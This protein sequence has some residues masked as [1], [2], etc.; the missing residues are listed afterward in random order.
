MLNVRSPTGK[1][2]GRSSHF[3]LYPFPTC[4]HVFPMPRWPHVCESTFYLFVRNGMPPHASAGRNS[5]RSFSLHLSCYY[6]DSGRK[7]TH[8]TSSVCVTA[9]KEGHLESASK[10]LALSDIAAP[11]S[12]V[13]HLVFRAS[14]LNIPYFSENPWLNGWKGNH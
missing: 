11:P 2:A 8:P 7:N 13:A 4:M 14:P 1:S 3:P 12:R 10:N 6:I 9:S 5:E